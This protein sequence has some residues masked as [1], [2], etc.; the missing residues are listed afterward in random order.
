MGLKKHYIFRS[1]DFFVD[2]LRVE[3]KW[4]IIIFAI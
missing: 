2:L 4:S 3:L 1:Q